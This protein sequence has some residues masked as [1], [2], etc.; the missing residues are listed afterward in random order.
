[1][2][3]Y[4]Y[5]FDAQQYSATVGDT[6]APPATV[7]MLSC[8]PSALNDCTNKLP[9]WPPH[10]TPQ[11]EPSTRQ[12]IA[13]AEMSLPYLVDQTMAQTPLPMPVVKYA[14]S[15]VTINRV[16]YWISNDTLNVPV[17]SVDLFVAPQ[18]TTDADDPKAQLIGSIT[19]VPARATTCL[20]QKDSNP[21][22]AAGQ[23]PICDVALSEAGQAALT[24]Y[25]QDYK[26][27]PFNLIAHTKIVARAGDP[28]PSGRLDFGVRPTVS[29]WILK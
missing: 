1:M 21:D 9:S 18:A 29:F 15:K 17:P 4:D 10:I 20:D 13:V 11:C 5:S 16:A 23:T 28:M 7:P 26:T 27:T 14:V 2:L 12:C 22:T 24:A 19:G 25:V 6:Q 8:N 3:R